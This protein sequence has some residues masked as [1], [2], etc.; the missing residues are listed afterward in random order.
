MRCFLFRTK[1]EESTPP[2][3][4]KSNILLLNLIWNCK[5]SSSHSHFFEREPTRN[6]I[7]FLQ[8]FGICYFSSKKLTLTWSLELVFLNSDVAKK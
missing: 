1:I 5:G 7:L 3:K 8:A 4:E 6:R 2:S